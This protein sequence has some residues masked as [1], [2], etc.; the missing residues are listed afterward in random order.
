MTQKFFSSLST[1]LM[2]LD[3]FSSI[4]YLYHTFDFNRQNQLFLSLVIV[5]A[6]IS[7]SVN[8]CFFVDDF[9]HRLV[10][11]VALLFGHKLL[12]FFSSLKF[13]DLHI[14]KLII[15]LGRQIFF[16]IFLNLKIMRHYSLPCQ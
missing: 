3:D 2:T 4:C 6:L 5:L 12:F 7:Y 1:I 13:C 15:S 10:I 11:F 9:E 16:C 14:S 8:K